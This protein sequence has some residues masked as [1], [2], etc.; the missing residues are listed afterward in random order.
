MLNDRQIDK[1]VDFLDDYTTDDIIVIEQDDG[2]VDIEFNVTPRRVCSPY[3][4]HCN[5]SLNDINDVAPELEKLVNTYGVYEHCK[6]I[7]A[8]MDGKEIDI[9]QIINDLT[10]IQKNMYEIYQ[11]VDELEKDL[12]NLDLGEER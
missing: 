8:V 11:N 4:K 1:I 5:I 7:L 2:V 10:E 9:M 12:H 6:D 3:F